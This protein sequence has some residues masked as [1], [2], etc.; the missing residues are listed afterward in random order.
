MIKQIFKRLGIILLFLFFCFLIFGIPAIFPWCSK[1]Y[2]LTYIVNIVIILGIGISYISIL[3]LFSWIFT[4]RLLSTV[5]SWTPFE[6]CRNY[7][8]E[9]QIYLLEEVKAK[10]LSNQKGSLEIKE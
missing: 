8:T 10:K 2:G 4:G 6:I 7:K 1:N 3:Q 9:K 5:E